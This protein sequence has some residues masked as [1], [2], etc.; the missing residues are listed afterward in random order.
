MPANLE[1]CVEQ[2][3]KQG[4]SEE[5]AWAICKSAMDGVM[6]GDA[7][8]IRATIDEI[9]GFLTAPVVLARTGVQTY[10]GYE[11]G[12]DGEKAL[13]QIGV[14]RPPEQV[15]HKDA[16]TSFEN[17]VVTDDHPSEAVTID[18]ERHL[19]MSRKLPNH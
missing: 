4:K 5:S 15:F 18:N 6:V 11:L 12:L 3:M 10:Y 8:P 7:A 2:V 17:M 19:Y 14:F 1:R 16:L 13:E 9:S